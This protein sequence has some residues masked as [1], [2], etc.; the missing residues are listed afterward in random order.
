VWKAFPSFAIARQSPRFDLATAGDDDQPG[1][2]KKIRR[3]VGYTVLRQVVRARIQT[4]AQ[5]G[6]L[7]CNKGTVV[8]QPSGNTHSQI[9]PLGDQVDAPR[10]K[11]QLKLYLRIGLVKTAEQGYDGKL[12]TF[13]RHRD[14]YRALGYHLPMQG[15]RFRSFGFFNQPAGVLEDAFAKI[16]DGQLARAP[17]KQAFSQLVFQ[18]G[19]AAR[20][21][22]FRQ[23][24]TV[25]RT[26]EASRF[27]H[28]RKKYQVVRS[29]SH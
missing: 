8:G 19:Y 5:H 6:Y 26:R 10:G 1:V 4:I 15:Q 20:Q 14:P 24:D 29:Q 23:T 17:G 13:R 9:E 21:C 11:V 18:L 22:G 27:D 28:M 12:A 2:M 3:F 7:S 25:R 16:G